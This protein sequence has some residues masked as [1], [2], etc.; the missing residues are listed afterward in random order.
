MADTT[1]SRAARSP[2]WAL[3]TRASSA[4]GSG[5]IRLVMF[6]EYLE[7]LEL[8]TERD[9][10]RFERALDRLQRHRR[11]VED[12]RV[13]GSAMAE[14]NDARVRARHRAVGKRHLPVDGPGGG[15]GVRDE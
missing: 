14:A 2:A 4:S 6:Q 15:Q 13:N 10:L 1:S 5:S 9:A 8:S 3:R 7:P 12:E 11:R